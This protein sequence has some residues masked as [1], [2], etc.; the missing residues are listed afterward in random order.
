MAKVSQYRHPDFAQE[1][2]HAIVRGT[3]ENFFIICMLA[4]DGRIGRELKGL[5]LNDVTSYYYVRD[6]DLE[7]LG[8]N[9][10]LYALP[11]PRRGR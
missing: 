9:D 11:R 4:S 8:P 7:K 2:R 6:V 10:A 1:G 3:E 5:Y